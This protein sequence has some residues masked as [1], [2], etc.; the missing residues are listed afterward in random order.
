MKSPFEIFRMTLRF[1]LG[2]LLTA[3]VV[4]TLFSLFFSTDVEKALKAENDMYSRILPEIQKEDSRRA[5]AIAFL[6]HRDNAI[7]EL[8]FHSGAPGISSLGGNVNDYSDAPASQ[9]ELIRRS[10]GQSDSLMAAASRVDSIFCDIFQTLSSDTVCLPMLL[11]ARNLSY[12][13]VGAGQGKKISPF[14]N[15]LVSHGGLDL[16]MER[17]DTVYATAAGMAVVP[18]AKYKKDGTVLELHHNGGYVTRFSHLQNILVSQWQQ[19]K[20]GQAVATVGMTGK[21]YAPHLHYEISLDGE[22]RDPINYIFASV[23]PEEYFNMLYMSENT[24]QSMD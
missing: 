2:T 16:V 23:S 19:V 3:V 15:A 1:L 8:V 22:T 17:G 7:Y 6:Q 13:Q 9:G 24:V 20:A 12:P 11:P 5:D 21:S 18:S 4:Y 10:F 14:L